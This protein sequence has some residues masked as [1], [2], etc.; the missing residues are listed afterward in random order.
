VRMVNHHTRQ[1]F[2]GGRAS[3]NQLNHI[4]FNARQFFDPANVGVA[5]ASWNRTVAAIGQA[6]F[7]EGAT[8]NSEYTTTENDGLIYLAW[9]NPALTPLADAYQVRMN[10]ED[11]DVAPLDFELFDDEG[12][13]KVIEFRQPWLLP[14]EQS[15][16]IQ[17]HYYRTGDDEMRPIGLWVKRSRDLRDLTDVRSL[18]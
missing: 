5:R 4:L 6:S 3:G 1:G 12:G 13:D 16:R 10:T 9:Y 8:A 11:F 7:F 14:P 2:K 15:G 17:V 18:A